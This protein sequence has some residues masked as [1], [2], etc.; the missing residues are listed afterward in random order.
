MAHLD[1]IIALCSPSNTPSHYVEA[2]RLA[3][4]FAHVR[5]LLLKNPEYREEAILRRRTYLNSLSPE[6]PEHNRT[7]RSLAQL[8]RR[9]FDKTETGVKN[10]LPELDSDDPEIMTFPHSHTWPHLF[11]N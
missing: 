10:G 8:K 7:M 9:R 3:A 4:Y 6:D 1:K 5:F 2:L 11:L